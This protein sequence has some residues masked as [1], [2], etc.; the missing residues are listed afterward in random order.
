MDGYGVLSLLPPVLA[1]GLAITTRQVIFSLSIGIVSGFLILADFNI[2]LALTNSVDGLV[3][4]FKEDWA[5]K[6]ILFTMMV[7]GIIHLS[8]VTG[9]TRGLVELL[10]EKRSVVNG[11]ISTQLL[12]AAIACAV[13]IDSYLAMLTSG[14]VTAE[15]AKKHRV[16]REQLAYVTKNTG[17]SVWSSVMING[18]GAAMMGIIAGQVQM[19]YIQGQPFSIL[20]NSMIYNLFA[21]SSILVVFLTLFAGLSFP[22]MRRANARAAAGIELREGAIPMAPDEDDA[23]EITRT[24]KVSNLLLPLLTTIGFTPVGL[25]ITGNGVMSEG[26]GSTA[27]LWAVLLGQ[28]VAFLYYVP[29]QRILTIEGYYKHLLTGYQEMVPL[30]AVLTLAILIGSVAGQLEIGNFIAQSVGGYVAP[31]M[32]AAFIF[33]IAG[34][35]SLSTG[36]SWGTFAIM[37]PIGI[38]LAVASGVDPYLAIGAAIS[39]SVLGD[40]VSPIS[41]TGIMISTA[42]KNDLM[43]HIK[44][45]LPY[46]LT[47]AAIALAG[48]VVLGIVTA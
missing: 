21:W 29:V 10:T 16:S 23:D 11:P 37:I 15:L 32:I 48:F 34:I 25:Y 38:Q 41:D 17:I 7:S 13:F 35:I 42:T 33:V 44:S 19:N 9:G 43:D 3:G 6:V 47:A 1:I 12:G 46:C 36:T 28:L 45:Q 5:V 2:P 8:K 4:I 27:V 20:A 24:G 22:A 39:G 18:W 40:T 30:V 14:A 26:S 31:S